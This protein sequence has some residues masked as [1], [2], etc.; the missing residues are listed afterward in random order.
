LSTINKDEHLG[1]QRSIL[2]MIAT[3]KR[4]TLLTADTAARLRHT[5]L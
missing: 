3:G 2:R 1:A 5:E 4:P